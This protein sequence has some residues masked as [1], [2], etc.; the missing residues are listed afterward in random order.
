MLYAFYVKPIIKRKQQQSVYQ[1]VA[2]AE[3]A[4]ASKGD[5][6]MTLSDKREVLV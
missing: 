5:R 2:A 1:A 3:S 6:P 4:A